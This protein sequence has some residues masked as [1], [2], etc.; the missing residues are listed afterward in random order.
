MCRSWLEDEL[1]LIRPRLVIPV[2]KLAIGYF[3]GDRPLSDT[4]GRSH[5]AAHVGGFSRVIPLPHPSGASSWIHMSGHQELVARALELIGEEMRQLRS[6]AKP[7][8]RSAA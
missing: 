2:G 3:L 6:A 7:S 8:K 4:V 5:E 1:R